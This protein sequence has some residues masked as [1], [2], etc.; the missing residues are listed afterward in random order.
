MKRKNTLLIVD[1]L[2]MNR[3]ILGNIFK[4]NYEIVE[5]CDGEEA[6]G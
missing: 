5:V 3:A 1:D 2:E 6:L 4:K